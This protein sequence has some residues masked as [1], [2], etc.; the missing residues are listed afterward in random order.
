MLVS[1]VTVADSDDEDGVVGW[2]SCVCGRDSDDED[3]VVCWC[4]CL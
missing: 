3:E 4:L 1:F 2:R